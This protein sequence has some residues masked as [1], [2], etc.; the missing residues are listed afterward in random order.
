M[1]T[2]NRLHKQNNINMHSSGPLSS[3]KVYF[4][5]LWHHSNNKI[6][7][8]IWLLQQVYPLQAVQTA[9]DSSQNSSAILTLRLTS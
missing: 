7:S 6:W 4:Q 3:R 8:K 1:I 2:F 9:T 5:H